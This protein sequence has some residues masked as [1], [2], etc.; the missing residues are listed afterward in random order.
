[1]PIRFR[2][3]PLLAALAALGFAGPASATGYLAAQVGGF[4][5]WNG[6]AG[7]M[8]SIQ[9]LGSNA[10]GR[11]RWGGEFEYREFDSKIAGVRNV[12]V[13]TYLLRGMWQY[14]FRPDAVATPYIGLGLALAIT[15]LD[16][17]KVDNAKGFNAI[18]SVGAGLDGVFLLGVAVNVPGAEYL[19]IFA[20][21]RIGLAFDATGRGSRSG[22]TVESVG[23]GSGSAG[24]R[25]RF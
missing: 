2:G 10:S 22:V 19:S 11:S 1:M 6:D 9:M 24:L 13:D 7:V 4:A 18:D 3:F 5:P 8:T 17:D 14:H 15:S 16:D 25:F 12:G 21:G 20:E 23:G